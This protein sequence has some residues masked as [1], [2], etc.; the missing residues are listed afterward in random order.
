MRQ[1][2]L[3]ASGYE[4]FRKKTR[5]ELLLKVIDEIIGDIY[6]YFVDVPMKERTQVKKSKRTIGNVKQ[7]VY[8]VNPH[9]A[10]PQ[11]QF[12]KFLTSPELGVTIDIPR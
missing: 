5:K 12:F 1:Q 4:I 3:E 10:K 9:G 8:T 2:S 11:I 7:E 6:G